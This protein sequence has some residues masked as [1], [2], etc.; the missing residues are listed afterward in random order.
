MVGVTYCKPCKAFSGK[1][2]DFAERFSNA[3]FLKIFGNEN[4]DMTR[5]ARDMLKVKSTPSFYILRD[6]EVVH[7]HSGANAGKF[8][9]AMLDNS[10]EGD[11][12]YGSEPLF[13]E[14]LQKAVKKDAEKAAAEAKK[15]A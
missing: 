8:E 11:E 4:K 7:F 3:R 2:K 12:G 9:K 10:R 6:K 1:Y 15:A 13:A 14:E 5:L